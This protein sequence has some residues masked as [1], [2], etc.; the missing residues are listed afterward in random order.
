[1]LTLDHY[2]MSDT[3][4]LCETGFSEVAVIKVRY[5]MKGSVERKMRVILIPRSEIL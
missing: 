2:V 4:Y 5:Y 1:M 3:S